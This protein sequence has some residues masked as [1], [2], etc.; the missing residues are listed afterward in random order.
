VGWECLHS[1]SSRH[2]VSDRTD[3]CLTVSVIA[4]YG[5]LTMVSDVRSF[6]SGLLKSEE[7]Y[8]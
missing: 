3:Q 2:Q 7:L 1:G 4:I 8:V 6:P 5:E